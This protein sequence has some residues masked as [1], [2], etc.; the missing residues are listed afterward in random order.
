[1]E[2]APGH[3]LVLCDGSGF[4]FAPLLRG[5]P[6]SL[7]VE[8]LNFHNDA[9]AIQRHGRGFG[10]GQIVKFA[11][12]N[13]NLIRENGFFAKCTSKL[14]IENFSECINQ[15][16]GHMLLKG[17]FK[18]TFSPT[19]ETQFEYIDTRFY[20]MEAKFYQA[21]FLSA[22]EFIQAENGHGLEECFKEVY[23]ALGCPPCL[24]KNPPVI[25]GVGGGTGKYYKNTGLRRTKE[26]LRYQII[27]RNPVFGGWFSM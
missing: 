22:H 10:E 11:L 7:T 3:P 20:V 26:R 21:H 27:Q 16:K 15:W 17:V 25:C 12:T 5:L 13:S 2:F 24:M 1:M 8:C 14:W 19:L 18:N 23:L 4:D 9:V 6:N